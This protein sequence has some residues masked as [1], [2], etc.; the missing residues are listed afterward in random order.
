MKKTSNNLDKF[1]R[2]LSVVTKTISKKKIIEINYVEKE[3]FFDSNTANIKEPPSNLNKK[4][5]NNVRGEA[6]SIGLQIR[7][8]NK[9][10]HKKY[11]L[12]ESDASKIFD[13]LEKSRC[14]SL[15]SINPFSKLAFI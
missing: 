9:V 10:I 4:N 11:N 13:L 2:N 15:G 6:D 14:E 7:Y 1:K 8:H 3:S 12:E 5:I